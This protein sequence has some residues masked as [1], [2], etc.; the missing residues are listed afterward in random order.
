MEKENKI[1]ELE[2]TVNQQAEV[3]IENNEKI[4]RLQ[5]VRA[6]QQREIKQMEEELNGM[7]AAAYN[8]LADM[9]FRVANE[10]P[11]V[12]GIFTRRTKEDVEELQERLIRDAHRYFEEAAY[13]GDSYAR[14]R[15]SE[16]KNEFAFLP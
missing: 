16:L 9:L 12:R 6:S 8:D 4:D 1:N 15:I 2:S 5:E 13:F 14:S 11:E 3:I 7:K 10:M